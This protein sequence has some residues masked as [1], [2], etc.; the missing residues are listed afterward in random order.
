MHWKRATVSRLNALKSSPVIYRTEGT[1][2]FEC[3]DE[4]Y[5]D[6]QIW[7][8]RERDRNRNPTFKDYYLQLPERVRKFIKISPRY[9]HANNKTTYK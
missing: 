7:S 2:L 4:L 6:F 8:S 5:V 1:T 9:Q 3:P